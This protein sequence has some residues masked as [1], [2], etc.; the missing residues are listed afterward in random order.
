MPLLLML[1]LFEAKLYSCV[2]P[3]AAAARLQCN[4][5]MHVP[6]SCSRQLLC[7]MHLA[8]TAS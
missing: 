8:Y 2:L 3:L 1:L 7:I 5:A 6:N 4:A